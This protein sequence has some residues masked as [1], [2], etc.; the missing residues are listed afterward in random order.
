MSSGP[1]LESTQPHI[2]WVPWTLSSGV[3]RPGR[4]ADHSSPNSAEVKKTVIY[5][6]FPPYAFIA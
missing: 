6:S 4:E 2:Q 3:K 1:I 5:A